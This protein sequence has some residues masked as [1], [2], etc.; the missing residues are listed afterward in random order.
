MKTDERDMSIVEVS[1]DGFC[2]LW[3]LRACSVRIIFGLFPDYVA[4]LL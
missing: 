1:A 4:R 3:S 2:L